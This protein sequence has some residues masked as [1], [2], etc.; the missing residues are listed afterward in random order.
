MARRIAHL[1][2]KEKEPARRRATCGTKAGLLEAVGILGGR[3][4]RVNADSCQHAGSWDWRA[5]SAKTGRGRLRATPDRRHFA[6]PN[7]LPGEYSMALARGADLGLLSA[8]GAL[9]AAYNSLSDHHLEQPTGSS[10]VRAGRI[11]RDTYGTL[12]P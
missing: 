5:S 10:A 7:G 2:N 11:L 9:A 1:T 6:K 12:A 8:T 3:V 4:G